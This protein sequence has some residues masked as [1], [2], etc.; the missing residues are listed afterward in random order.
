MKKSIQSVFLVFVLLTVVLSG[1]APAHKKLGLGPLPDDVAKIL[2]SAIQN[3]YCTP[4]SFTAK[5][6]R[7]ISQMKGIASGYIEIDSTGP[8]LPFAILEGSNPTLNPV[9]PS[10]LKIRGK[11]DGTDISILNYEEFVIQVEEGT[12][13]DG[14]IVPKG[15]SLV[16]DNG[17]WVLIANP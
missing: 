10:P 14:V 2:D 5:S 1:C 11:T 8:N 7:M 13:F 3:Q 6:L 17:S 16:R 9:S 15:T 4:N 12:D